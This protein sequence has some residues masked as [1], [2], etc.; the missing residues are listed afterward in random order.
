[1]NSRDRLIQ[2]TARL[3][4]EKGMAATGLSE[5][6]ALA[7]LPKGSLYHYFPGGKEELIREALQS[8]K[9]WLAEGFKSKMKGNSTAEGGL[10]GIVDYFIEDLKA[11]QFTAGCPI[12]TVA[13]ESNADLPGIAMAVREVMDYWIA[14]LS[15]YLQYKGMAGKRCTAEEFIIQLEGALIMA[16]I[17][18]TSAPL[19]KLKLKIKNILQDDHTPQIAEL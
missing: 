10:T 1:M 8:Y 19:E 6:L 13:L 11:S 7:G 5:I 14:S 9:N 17:Y 4:R 2:V 15:A 3:I 16:R 12:A 18:Q